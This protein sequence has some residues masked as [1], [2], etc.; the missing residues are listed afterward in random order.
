MAMWE[1][2]SDNQEVILAV[3]LGAGVICKSFHF[4]GLAFYWNMT[5][6]RAGWAS[7]IVHHKTGV[8]F[9]L[10]NLVTKLGIR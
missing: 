2:L 4:R 8:F 6:L 5:K 9:Q 1:L 3:D 10:W 7:G